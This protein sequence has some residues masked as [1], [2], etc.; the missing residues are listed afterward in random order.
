VAG[1]IA[2]FRIDGRPLHVGLALDGKEFLHA[3]RGAGS[4][5]ERFASPSWHRRFV[6]VYRHVG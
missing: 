4:A 3:D 6:S 5:V 1:D 2:L